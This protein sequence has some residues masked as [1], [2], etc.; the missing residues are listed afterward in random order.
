MNIDPESMNF[1]PQGWMMGPGDSGPFFTDDTFRH[2]EV[3]NEYFSRFETLKANL[4]NRKF[5]GPSMEVPE[6]TYLRKISVSE[7]AAFAAH[8]NWEI[9]EQLRALKPATSTLQIPANERG[10]GQ[11]AALT[12]FEEVD[13]Y[14]AAFS[15]LVLNEKAIDWDFWVGRMPVLNVA[16]AA[17]LMAALDPHV[18]EDL[19]ARPNRNDPSDACMVARRIERLALAGR[20]VEMSPLEW[21]SWA[22]ENG[23]QPCIGFR[24]AVNKLQK[25]A[26]PS[27]TTEAEVATTSFVHSTKS[28]RN[29][30]TPVIELAQAQ[31]RN[32][33]DTAEVW[34]ALLVLAEKQSPPLR[35]ATE[36]GIQYLSNGV[37]EIFKRDSLRKRLAR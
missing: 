26:A 2:E 23:V 13:E 30:L 19:R 5:F 16:E 18:F 35:G 6:L 27:P 31:C 9:P 11:S 8:C 20:K 10:E 12:D 22:Q 3:K 29:A 32:P 37:A 21:L 34:A 4:N 28:R 36:E 33:R 17:R 25:E 1:H 7:L 24:L 15:E 14:R